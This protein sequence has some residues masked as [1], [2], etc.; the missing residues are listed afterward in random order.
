MPGEAESGPNA[1]AWARQRTGNGSDKGAL[2]GK[3]TKVAHLMAIGVHL[4]IAWMKSPLARET[5]RT[6]LEA[7][8]I[9]S[10][11]PRRGRQAEQLEIAH[12][13]PIG[14]G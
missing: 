13:P 14:I 1:V 2:R 8:Q 12:G 6:V 5:S 11:S 9:K 3:G 7:G 10:L 4:I